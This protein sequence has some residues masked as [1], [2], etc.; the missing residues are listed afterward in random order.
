MAR[1][2]GSDGQAEVRL[3]ARS[4]AVRA[5]VAAS[6]KSH[7]WQLSPF[8]LRR[9]VSFAFLIVRDGVYDSV[10][11]LSLTL[12]AR[13]IVPRRAHVCGNICAASHA[14]G[15]AQ[16]A[17]HRDRGL[18]DHRTYEPDLKCGR[19]RLAAGERRRDPVARDD[20]REQL[21]GVEA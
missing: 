6:S 8:K 9:R 16:L 20:F 3:Q 12:C 1:C 17:R 5:A 2:R 19:A 21:V 13:S 15:V 7:I 4:G 10:R 18:G 14:Q 11:G